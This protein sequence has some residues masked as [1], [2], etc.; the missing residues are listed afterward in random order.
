MDQEII[1]KKNL[2]LMEELQAD[3][4]KEDMK[5]GFNSAAFEQGQERTKKGKSLSHKIKGLRVLADKIK[6]R[7]TVVS[8]DMLTEDMIKTYEKSTAFQKKT[9][10]VWLMK[11]KMAIMQKCRKKPLKF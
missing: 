9:L 2:S 6:S 3:L 1:Q 7:G 10:S 8:T 11:C 4:R 5:I